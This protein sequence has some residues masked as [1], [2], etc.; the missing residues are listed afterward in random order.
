MFAQSKGGDR[1]GYIERER[2]RERKTERDGEW[3][4]KI[5]RDRSTQV[6]GGNIN[7]PSN[8][9][10]VNAKIGWTFETF[11]DLWGHTNLNEIF[12]S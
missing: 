10:R 5:E 12:A 4:R 9:G 11:N 8:R 1:K 6:G 2:V 7:G 3:E